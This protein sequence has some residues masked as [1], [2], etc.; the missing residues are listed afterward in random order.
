MTF[1][2]LGNIKKKNL[3][4]SNLT[5]FTVETEDGT[6]IAAFK[7]LLACSSTYFECLFRSNPSAKSVRLNFEGTKLKKIINTTWQFDEI[8]LFSESVDNLLEYYMISDYL[9]MDDLTYGKGHSH[10]VML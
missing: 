7:L 3:F 4:S 10:F 2:L 8:N 9:L 6:E 1:R 5:D